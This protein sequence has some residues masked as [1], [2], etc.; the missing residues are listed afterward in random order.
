MNTSRISPLLLLL[1][2][3]GC[4]DPYNPSD[5]GQNVGYLVV[6]SFVNSS[7]GTGTVLL[8][9]TKPLNSVDSFQSVT[10]AQVVIETENGASFNFIESKPG[11]YDLA[12]A[13]IDSSKKYRMKILAGGVRYESDVVAVANTPP[14]DSVSWKQVDD[15][16]EVYANTHD[17]GNNSHFY[18]W[19]FSEAWHYTA[20]FNSSFIYNKTMHWIEPRP[21][22][23]NIYDCYKSRDASDIFIYSTNA[24]QS[25]IVKEYKLTSF[26]VSSARMEH[27][28]S[29]EVQQQVLT[30]AGYD[31][32]DMLKKTTENLGSLF[33]PQPS[34]VTGNFHCITDPALPVIGF[35]SVGS[36]D[37]KRIFINPRQVDFNGVGPADPFYVGCEQDTL[38]STEIMFFTGVDI[39]TSGAYKGPVFLGY[40]KTSYEC[41]DCRVAGGT[42]TKPAYWPK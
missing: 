38:T 3:I 23:Q 30:Q 37:K 18:R 12:G 32:F 2:S 20:A 19:R 26:P 17:D 6:D 39:I 36:T 21:A 40:L 9:R 5:N 11:Q 1:L 42:T 29:I 41:G 27:L 8:T 7:D 15:Q 4:L 28:Y 35:F 13:T 24:L 34:Q 14:I 25:D 16:I 33:D 10:N 22:S 31:Y